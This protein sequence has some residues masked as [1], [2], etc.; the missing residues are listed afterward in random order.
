G[1]TSSC[2]SSATTRAPTAARASCRTPD[3]AIPPARRISFPAKASKPVHSSSSTKN[4][5]MSRR[6]FLYLVCMIAAYPTLG[7]AQD[8]PPMRIILPVSAGSGVDTITRASSNALSK[9][10]GQPV[11]V[12][13]LPGAGGITGTQA[14][15]KSRT[16][17]NTISLVSNN[18]VINP[19]VY[20]KMPFDSVEDITPITIIGTQPPIIYVN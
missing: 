10:L 20:A 19:S 17:G 14:L 18:H 12:E 9:A 2:C 8:R 11:V 5:S 7:V 4:R 16:D 6:S 13:N 1:P 3:F 15:V